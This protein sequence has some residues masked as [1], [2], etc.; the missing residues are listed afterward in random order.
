M[1]QIQAW[2]FQFLGW[3]PWLVLLLF[4]AGSW[5][6]WR[7]SAS[8]WR[9]RTV[10]LR[11]CAWALRCIALG[12]VLAMLAEPIISQQYKQTIKAQ[13][14]VVLD[15]SAS[16]HHNDASMHPTA[17]FDEMQALKLLADDQRSHVARDCYNLLLDIRELLKHSSKQQ[18]HELALRLFDYGKRL[19]HMY[20]ALLGHP[21]IADR[22]EAIYTLCFIHVDHVEDEGM[23]HEQ[24]KKLLNLI[25]SGLLQ[26]LAGVQR[27]ADAALAAGAGG[28]AV[29][30]EQ[31]QQWQQ[32]SRI[33]RSRRFVTQRLQP[34][35][36]SHVNLRTVA[37][38]TPQQQFTDSE[39]N[40]IQM[41]SDFYACLDAL[42][43]QLG[44]EQQHQVL[45]ISDGMH[46]GERD[47][48]SVA[49]ALGARG[50]PIHSLCIGDADQPRDAVITEI[51]GPSELYRAD[52]I[53]ITVRYRITGYPGQ[54]WDMVL[55]INGNEYGRRSVSGNGLLQESHFN[56]SGL[57]ATRLN[58]VAE[59][60]PQLDISSAAN[61]QQAWLEDIWLSQKNTTLNTFFEQE[62]LIP[63]DS[64]RPVKQQHIE[65]NRQDFFIRRL[66]AYLLAPEDGWYQFAISADD[67]GM[68]L[69]ST[70]HQPQ[71]RSLIAYCERAVKERQ[72]QHTPTQTSQRVYLQKGAAYY[73][74]VRQ[75]DQQHFD[76]IGIGWK[77]PGEQSFKTIPDKQLVPYNDPAIAGHLEHRSE[78]N[79]E[80]NRQEHIII[81][82]SDP[83][84]ILLIDQY[85]RWETRLISSVLASDTGVQLEA[86][87]AGLQQQHQGRDVFENLERFDALFLGDVS[88]SMLSNEIQ[89]R[90]AATVREHGLLLLVIAGRNSMPHGFALGP[91]ADIL[92]VSVN[93]TQVKQQQRWQLQASS[94][95][96]LTALDSSQWQWSA[97]PPMRWINGH[98]A[99]REQATR[100]LIA[101]SLSGLQL[102]YCC[103][104][105]IGAG[106]VIY[107]NAD[108]SWRWRQKIG[109]NEH[110]KWWRHVMQ[111][112]L[113][114]RLHGSDA[115]LR[116]A[117][118]QRQ[119]DHAKQILVHARCFAQSRNLND[120]LIVTLEQVGTSNE[121]W[122]LAMPPAGEQSQTSICLGD[123]LSLAPGQYRVSVRS[124]A[125]PKLLEQ[126]EFWI[127]PRHQTELNRLGT[128][129]HFLKRLAGI[130]DGIAVNL[131]NSQDLIDHLNNTLQQ[132][133]Q[134]R[135]TILHVWRSWYILLLVITLL[136]AEWLLRKRV[137]LP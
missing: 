86:H 18:Q 43:R 99:V 111:W 133:E 15:D 78:H 51:S 90:I 101:E 1:N 108:E 100:H 63:S 26:A 55:T 137:G 95:D 85:P 121:H 122:Q 21:F 3:P 27:H 124:K 125:L 96:P 67:E 107:F 79:K 47:P 112:G 25:D 23:E 105:H 75:R 45:L 33:D 4:T 97:L 103:S 40:D 65:H 84:R 38:H 68:L 91:L 22:I 62:T 34:E 77:T 64:S 9:E 94:N 113:Q 82:H 102:I 36:G 12:L 8:E 76:H 59:L 81:A 93:A 119:A 41:H 29:L 28:S 109:K 98:V 16:M 127:R 50:I 116:V 114:S 71:H 87:Y 115:R 92:P 131:A 2:E 42:N 128:D 56:V 37:L 39:Q 72:W 11:V 134:T 31:M 58:I 118:S 130:S 80:N 7:F 35:L 74:E 117:I 73:L 69:L 53:P 129:R 123:H 89:D 126:R 30:A 66:R 88:T 46:N 49:R 44:G 14:T 13:L 104:Q 60:K 24:I 110:R 135:V 120:S 52:D 61:Q 6:L 136:S 106:R 132:R 17:R 48:S 57:P 54:H 83:L 20:S 19:K 70:D 10:W 32:M 5:G